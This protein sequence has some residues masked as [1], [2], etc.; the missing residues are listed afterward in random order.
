MLKKLLK[1]EK[2][3]NEWFLKKDYFH[4]LFGLVFA[5]FVWGVLDFELRQLPLSLLIGAIMGGGIW[6]VQK[7]SVWGSTKT[8]E[9]LA[10]KK[11]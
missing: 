10:K 7:I 6:L 4:P 5:I 2:K 9:L 11:K 8:L 3:Y 1:L